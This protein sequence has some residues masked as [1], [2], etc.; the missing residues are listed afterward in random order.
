MIVKRLPAVVEYLGQDYPLYYETY[1]EA[2]SKIADRDLLHK[3]YKYLKAMDKDFLMSE[4]FLE[5][6]R[7]ALSGN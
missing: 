4:Y 7:N 5:S 2:E 6:V 1:A 3:G